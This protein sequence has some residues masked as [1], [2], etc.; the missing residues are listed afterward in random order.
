MQST[1][2]ITSVLTPRYAETT[3][4]PR[5]WTTESHALGVALNDCFGSSSAGPHLR[6]S[7]SALAY[8][9]DIRGDEIIDLVSAAIGHKRPFVG[10]DLNGGFDTLNP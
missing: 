2:L 8:K 9:A 10:N 5:A 7:A 3:T 4:A 6:S 1:W